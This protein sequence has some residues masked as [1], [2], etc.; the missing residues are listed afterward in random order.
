[1]KNEFLEEL[2]LKLWGDIRHTEEWGKDLSNLGE[3]QDQSLKGKERKEAA[4][5]VQELPSG[6]DL[7]K[8]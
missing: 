6:L 2:D 8:R 4:W 7:L 3:I 5:C 1:M